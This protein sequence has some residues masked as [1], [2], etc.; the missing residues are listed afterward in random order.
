MYAIVETGGKQYRVEP[1]EVMAVEKLA[2]QPGETIELDRVALIEQ[3]GKVTVGAPW[4]GGA[5]VICRV[6]GHGRDRKIEVFT[7]KAKENYKRTLGHRQP[8]TRVRVEQIVVGVEK[9]G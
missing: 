1:N 8:Y 5:K 7:Y 9:E 3:D 2:A 6:L 4:V